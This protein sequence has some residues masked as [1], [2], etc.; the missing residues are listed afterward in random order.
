MLILIQDMVLLLILVH[1]FSVLIFDWGKNA[2]IF[3][4]D[5][6]SSVHVDNNK[7]FILV[8]SSR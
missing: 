7:K 1:F 2:I 8:L 6:S 3:G 5:N 4:V